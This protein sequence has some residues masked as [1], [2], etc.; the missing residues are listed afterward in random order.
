MRRFSILSWAFIV[1]ASIAQGQYFP[2]MAL[3]SHPQADKLKQAWYSD[4]LRAL[5]EPSLLP[6]T[7]IP[8]QECYRFLWL[9]TFNHPI[10]IRLVPKTN[11]TS[12]LIVKVASGSA[13]F[14]PGVLSENS[15]VILTRE[16][17]QGFLT[18]LDKVD[19][20]HIVSPVDDQ[21]GTDGSQWIIEGVKAGKY[22]LVDRWSPNNGPIRELGLMLAFD[23]AHMSIPKHDIY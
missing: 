23:L 21:T 5:Q 11:G 12:V 4:E 19:F 1:V 16:Q 6:L 20:W 14:H 10:S 3:D 9:R 13:G 8:S 17:T 2:K 22:H 7:K 18:L 15:T